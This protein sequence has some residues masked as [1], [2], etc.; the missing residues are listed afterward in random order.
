MEFPRASGILLHPTSLPGR[1]G[2]G[3]FG[4]GTVHFLDFLA[5]TGQHLWQVLPLGPT[6]YG[7]SPYQCLSAFAGNRLLITLE[8]LARQGYL[9][10]EELKHV[11]PLPSARVDYRQVIPLKTDLL[12]RAFQR[13]RSQA[14][15]EERRRFEDFC[16]ERAHWLDDY[17]LFKSLK[18][19]HQ[20]RAW[21]EWEPAVA[22]REPGA[23][24]RWKEKLSDEVEAHKFFQFV[25]FTQ[26]H[27]VRQRCRDR[28]IQIVGDVP[29]FVAHDSADVWAHRHLFHLDERGHP[30]KRAGV[31]PDYFSATGQ[32]WGNPLY[33]WDVLAETGYAWWIDRLKAALE[34][35]DIIRL[36]HFRGFEAYWEVPAGETTA[37]NGQWEKGPGAHFFEVVQRELGPLPI[38]AEDLGVITPEVVA[39]RERFRFP[40]MKVLQFAFGDDPGSRQFRPHNYP[41]NCVVYT[42]THD[43]DTTVGWFTRIGAG[44]TTQSPDEADRERQTALKYVG[45]DGRQIHWDFI[46]LALGSVANTAIVPLQDVLGLGSEA[47]MNLPGRPEGNWQWRFTEEMLTPEIRQQLADM[48]EVYERNRD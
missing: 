17:A 26:W 6:G 11:P 39:L 34:Q 2:I 35:V 45:T 38:I 32:L 23:L 13:F 28:R 16:R 33:R 15:A 5:E 21:T 43:N 24:R 27:E 4:P 22:A 30:T 42:G 37:I 8:Q 18:D 36:D 12:R 7:D 41:R 10:I 25:F 1:F 19:A 31:P 46:R 14:P 48:A 9:S 40:G 47:R 20:G 3:D 29:I 44:D